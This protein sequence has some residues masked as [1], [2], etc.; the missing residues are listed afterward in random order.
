MTIVTCPRHRLPDNAHMIEVAASTQQHEYSVQVVDDHHMM[1]LGLMALAASA[2]P[3]RLRWYESSNLDDA[4]ALYASA[5]ASRTAEASANPIDLVLLDLNLPDSK[6]LQGLRRFLAEWPQ[7]NIAVFSATEDEFVVSQALAMGAVGFVPKSSSAD[8]TLRLVES[9][10]GGY[11]A[12]G[13]TSVWSASTDRSRTPTHNL[14]ARAATLN[15]TQHKVLELVLAGMSNQEIATECKLALGT[16]KNTVSSIL[17]AM[18][19]R[20]RSHLITLFK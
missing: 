15:P 3:L 4:L 19:V 13:A 12:Q 20:S 11:R 7:A 1:R 14:H 5:A 8:T 9:L 18:D 17:L 10:L 6:G 2:S 16:V